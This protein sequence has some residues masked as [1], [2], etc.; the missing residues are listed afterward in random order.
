MSASEAT[1]PRRRVRR[2]RS[3][4]LQRKQT[5]LAWLML[6]PALLVVAFVAFYPLGTTVYQSF[7]NKSFLALEPTKWI[8]LDNYHRLIHDTAFRHSI[9]VTVKFTLITVSFEF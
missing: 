9:W 1:A 2:K 8:G 5:R 4:G 6:A 7:T 3:S